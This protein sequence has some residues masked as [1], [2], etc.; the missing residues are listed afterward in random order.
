MNVNKLIEKE[1]ISVVT[2]ANNAYLHFTENCIKSLENLGIH[3]L[4]TIYCL[5]QTCYDK[6]NSQYDN[7]KLIDHSIEGN[8][9]EMHTFPKRVTRMVRSRQTNTTYKEIMYMKHV[10]IEDG[11]KNSSYV[12]YIDGDVVFLKDD[13]LE[14]IHDRMKN[15][16][17]IIQRDGIDET[18]ERV[19]AGLM[20]IRNT[21]Q[22]RKIW[23]IKRAKS[24]PQYDTY[25]G[26]QDYVQCNFQKVPHD[27]MPLDFAPNGYY[28]NQY[29]G[30]IDPSIIH[31]NWSPTQNKK[32]EDMKKDGNWFI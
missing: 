1:N 15:K 30:K 25:I 4:L 27:Y 11:F 16:D 6:L 13:F 3:N 12:F 18:A 29:K 31:Y 7:I 9:S 10:I 26:D 2:L 24:D 19:C 17:L 28:F 20:H 14:K 32:V 5:D 21:E 8:I 22:T 23:D